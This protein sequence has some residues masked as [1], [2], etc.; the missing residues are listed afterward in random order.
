MGCSYPNF[1]E[2]V[3]ST[4][5]ENT[6]CLN[7]NWLG[8]LYFLLFSSML[9]VVIYGFAAYAA[10]LEPGSMSLHV[11]SLT[12]DLLPLEWEN[13]YSIGTLIVLMAKTFWLTL[14]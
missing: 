11:M 7:S 9:N 4:E 1:V 2:E 3:S 5:S 12:S 10:S 6:W 14:R 8:L 13:G